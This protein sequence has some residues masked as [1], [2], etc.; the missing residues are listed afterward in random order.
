MVLLNK[1]PNVS[2]TARAICIEQHCLKTTTKSQCGPV[3]Q[4]CV[5]EKVLSAE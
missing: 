5:L 1:N 2:R 3:R 4:L